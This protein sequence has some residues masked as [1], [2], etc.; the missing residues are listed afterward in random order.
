MSLS[1]LIYASHVDPEGWCDQSFERIIVG[2]RDFNRANSGTGMLLFKRRRFLQLLEGER[3]AVARAFARV[4]ADRRHRDLAI[5]SVEDVHARMC[6]EW[7]MAIVP[8]GRVMR[9]V[10]SRFFPSG[11]FEPH[12][13]SAEGAL[14]FLEAVVELVDQEQLRTI[15]A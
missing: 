1:R 4:Q 15:A 14:A 11:D 10:L 12:D 7:S 3:E 2:A 6:S 13:L 9:P 8:E 5:I